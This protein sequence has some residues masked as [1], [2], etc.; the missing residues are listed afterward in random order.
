MLTELASDRDHS[1][2]PHKFAAKQQQQLQEA[3]VQLKALT[4]TRSEHALV[5]RA[6]VA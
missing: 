4:S 1:H 5:V 3:R 6:F 2:C